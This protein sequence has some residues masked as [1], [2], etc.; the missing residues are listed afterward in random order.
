MPPE[1]AMTKILRTTS[2]LLLAAGC[3][4]TR[5]Q[6]KTM[7]FASVKTIGVLPFNNLSRD[8]IA[9]E[10]VRDVFSNLLLATGAAYVLPAGEVARGLARANV[11]LPATPSVEEVIAFGKLLQVNAV[12]G[13]TLKEYGEVRAGSSTAN[14]VSVSLQMYETQTGKVVWAA[15]STKG[16]IGWSDRLLGGGGEPMN[17]VTE[18]AVRDLL[19]KL[20][21]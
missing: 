6:D 17:K 10:R 15:E 18:D 5:Y 16:G 19:S 13:G 1:F 2:I 3:A 20:L 9:G 7:D 21:K 12:I 14:V 8:N 11:V 4:T